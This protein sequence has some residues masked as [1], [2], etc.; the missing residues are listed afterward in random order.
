MNDAN[1]GTSIKYVNE[2]SNWGIYGE[3]CAIKDPMTDILQE[4]QL[5]IVPMSLCGMLALSMRVNLLVE[6][7]AAKK[8]FLKLS[9]T[10]D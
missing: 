1:S 5:S 7:C 3:I 2:T 6:I 8:H 9:G 4:T 10:Y